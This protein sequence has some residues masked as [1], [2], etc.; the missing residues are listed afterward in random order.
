MPLLTRACRFGT[1]PL[2]RCACRRFAVALIFN[3]LIRFSAAKHFCPMPCPCLALRFMA[4][5][6]LSCAPQTGARQHCAAALPSRAE[7]TKATPL[8]FPA[9]PPRGH[10]LVRTA[11]LRRRYAAHVRTMQSR[12]GAVDVRSVTLPCP[13]CPLLRSAVPSPCE[14]WLITALPLLCSDRL[15][16]AFA[17]HFV[18]LLCRC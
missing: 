4:V 9:Q 8:Q 3:A 7:Q 18:T 16:N 12:C 13:C 5:P 2:H 11:P 14:T 10:A 17:L 15:R 1:L 6:Q